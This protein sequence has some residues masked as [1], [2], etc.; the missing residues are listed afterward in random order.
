MGC[1]GSET[2]NVVVETTP[3]ASF[4]VNNPCSGDTTVFTNATTIS[5][6]TVDYEWSLGDGT[7]ATTQNINY[8]YPAIGNFSVRL[9]ATTSGSTCKDTSIQSVDIYLAYFDTTSLSGDPSVTYNGTIYTA[10]TQVVE[11]LTTINGCDS[12]RVTNISVSAPTTWTGAVDTD[13]N[14]VSNWSAGIPDNTDDIVISGGGNNPVINTAGAACKNLTI[15]S[16]GS[17]TIS[18]A[19]YS[20]NLDTLKIENGAQVTISNGAVYLNNVINSG[21]LNI[22]GGTLDIDD[23][24]TASGNITTNISGGTI[25]VEGNWTSSGNGFDSN[26]W[27]SG[28]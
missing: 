1:F 24:Y 22:S 16:G 9:I 12:V 17:V 23:N 28:V 7:T 27:N 10:S 26:W 4:T 14:N 21:T 6:G 5:S 11:N 2:Q 15:S 20:I 3:V 13:W 18:D 8:D 19:S 25:K